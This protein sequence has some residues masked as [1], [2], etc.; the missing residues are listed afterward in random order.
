MRILNTTY[1]PVPPPDPMIAEEILDLCCTE[2]PFDPCAKVGKVSV[3][4]GA[5]QEDWDFDP[6]EELRRAQAE[7]AWKNSGR[8]IVSVSTEGV[9]NRSGKPCGKKYETWDGHNNCCDFVEPMAWDAETSTEVL[10]PG[11]RGIVGVTGG[12]PPYHWSVRGNGFSLD[13]YN[14]R[15]GWT[16]TPYTWIYAHD[17]ACGTAP[18]EVTD[19]CSTINAAIYS[20]VGE[21]VDCRLYYAYYWWGS[22]TT[23][24]LSEVDAAGCAIAAN[25]T[26]SPV[27]QAYMDVTAT[28]LT[29]NNT[30]SMWK[31]AGDWGVNLAGS[32]RVPSS[33]LSSLER[34]PIAIDLQEV[35]SGGVGVW[36]TR[37][38]GPDCSCPILGSCRYIC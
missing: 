27:W 15:D 6:D 5:E 30:Q 34:L 20:S 3:Y 13:G 29:W 37:M 7:E 32:N 14:L 33:F 9:G 38:P 28:C 4:Q 17:F 36:P 21:W 35:A 11:T 16:D 1:E 10:A 22:G 2:V 12:A 19:G 8:R 24:I 23:A 31:S 25:G 26:I 18:I